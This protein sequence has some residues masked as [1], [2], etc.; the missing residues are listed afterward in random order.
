MYPFRLIF[1]CVLLALAIPAS[2]AST[3]QDI[4]RLLNEGRGLEAK[5]VAIELVEKSDSFQEKVANVHL[6]LDVCMFIS[7]KVCFAKYWDANW[8]ELYKELDQLPRKTPEEIARKSAQ[9]DTVIAK[10]FY[11]LLQSPSKTYIA[12]QLTH[13]EKRVTGESHFEG[14]SLRTILEAQ[15]AAS[16]GDRA[17]ARRLIRRARAL[18]LTRNLNHLKEQLT[19]AFLV[20]TSAYALF[21]SQDLRRVLKSFSEAGKE[22]NSPIDRH[23]N[24]YVAI[25]I[26]RAISESDLLSGQRKDAIVNDMHMMY[27]TLQLA[28]GSTLSA[29]K[30]SF[31][32]YLALDKSWGAF[33]N[34]SFDPTIEFQK[35]SS[36]DNFDAIGV[37]AYLTSID[38]FNNQKNYDALD[39]AL[40]WFEVMRNQTDESTAKNFKPT[41]LILSSLKARMHGD[42]ESEA[43]LLE[44]YVDSQLEFFRG[45]G[46]T[47]LD[48]PPS[49]GGL[50]AKIIRYTLQR[51]KELRPNSQQIARL[52]SFAIGTF[53]SSK[54]GDAETSYAMLAASNSDLQ[55]QQIQ[56]RIRLNSI[57]AR[58]TSRSYFKAAKN[59]ITTSSKPTFDGGV[60]LLENHHLLEKLRTSDEQLKAL[61]S[62]P[63]PFLNLEVKQLAPSKKD[64]SVLMFAEADGYVLSLVIQENLAVTNIT[65]IDSIDFPKNALEVLRSKNLEQ[66]SIEEIHDASRKLS[67]LLLGATTKLG[68]SIE[69]L[70]GPTVLGIPYTLLSD[71]SSGK[72]LVDHAFVQTYVSPIQRALSNHRKQTKRSLDFVGFANPVLRSTTEQSTVASVE[73]MIRGA[74]GG[75]ETLA[76]LPETEEEVRAFAAPFHGKKQLYL[77]KEATIDNLIGLNLNNVQILSFSTHGVLAGEVDGAKSSSIVLSPTEKNNG[78]V[79]VEWL[80]SVSG[81]PTLAILSTCNSGTTALPLDDSELT[82]LASVFL[83][84]GSDA[85]ISSYWQVNSKGTLEIMRTLSRHVSEVQ[86]YSVAFSNAIRSVK[87]RSEWSHPSVWAAFVMLGSYKPDLSAPKDAGPV[88][89]IDGASQHWFSKNGKKVLLVSIEDKQGGWTVQEEELEQNAAAAKSTSSNHKYLRNT[90]VAVSKINAFGNLIATLEGN[91]VVFSS[92][93]TNGQFSKICTLK[94][95]SPDWLIGD[96]FR[97]KSY[98]YALFTRPVDEGV[99]YGLASLSI[100]GCQSIVKAPFN[101]KTGVRGYANL[102]L[103]PKE[104]GEKIIFSAEAP[105]A[106]TKD[107]FFQGDMTELGV[108]RSCNFD[109]DNVFM[110]LNHQLAIESTSTFANLRV[111]NIRLA[112]TQF[113]VIG[114]W[115]DPCSKR[116]SVRFLNDAFF[117]TQ[118]PFEKERLLRRND[119]SNAELEELVAKNFENIS[120]IWWE[121][122]AQFAYVQGTPIFPADFTDHITKESVSANSYYE[123]LFSFQNIYSY[124]LSSRK[125]NWIASGE[126]CDFAQPLG[127][128]HDDLFMCTDYTNRNHK[129]I[130]TLRRTH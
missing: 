9:T 93:E 82:S 57:Y 52:A 44:A 107:R 8:S 115:R 67:K 21:D 125:W 31:Y 124:E 33:Q 120:H 18:V 70:S 81:S 51:L 4:A 89:T 68:S 111:D 117:E 17:L 36:P 40:S 3:T 108:S 13:V 127:Y 54:N 37:K 7:D 94:D 100:D 48:P 130:I 109:S 106:A 72:W 118:Q 12:K 28:P 69:I 77:G 35:I 103:F 73:G 98:I 1:G 71:P 34:L 104:T 86:D 112:G 80:F 53:N 26:Y 43:N 29:Q 114:L 59:L 14:A 122:G 99:E 45:G 56:D 126:E 42:R 85:V 75:V 92:I 41:Y 116:T 25:R 10:Y 74:K 128:G 20:E 47:L 79:P 19:F 96:F 60:G 38:G 129:S 65:S 61:A 5:E 105:L 78:L 91:E 2:F 11:R 88:K 58:S 110:T 66:F 22:E 6:L 95:V 102:R 24:P 49:L 83:L 76:E 50:T 97:T 119:R 121:P 46:F 87:H 84:K 62:K 32:A 15:A 55:T 39:R 101:F 23:I 16:I 64:A 123:R 30:Q 90:T 63:S 113:G 27:Q